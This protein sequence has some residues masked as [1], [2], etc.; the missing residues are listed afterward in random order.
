MPITERDRTRILPVVPTVIHLPDPTEAEL[1]AASGT[2]EWYGYQTMFDGFDGL[3]RM[4]CVIAGGVR[5]EIVRAMERG[6]H[7]GRYLRHASY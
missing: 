3:Y 1:D 2:G 5:P 4:V 6:Y 7:Y